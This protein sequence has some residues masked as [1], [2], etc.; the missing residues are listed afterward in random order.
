MKHVGFLAAYLVGIGDRYA[1]DR[2]V[3][4]DTA[5]QIKGHKTG[6]RTRPRTAQFHLRAVINKIRGDADK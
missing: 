6:D 1:A 4:N 3:E 2:Q 5:E